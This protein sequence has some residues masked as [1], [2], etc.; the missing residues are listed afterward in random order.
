MFI[1]FLNLIL[2]NPMKKETIKE[3]V[4]KINKDGVIEEVK[5]AIDLVSLKEKVIQSV[6]VNQKSEIYG[7]LIF[8]L[9]VVLA[10]I[11][12]TISTPVFIAQYSFG[13]IILSV[14]SFLA[15]VYS[16]ILIADKGFKMK[17]DLRSVFRVMSYASIVLWPLVLQ[18][19]FSMINAYGIAR[20]FSVAN[21]FV[22]WIFVVLYF[23]LEKVIKMKHNDAI[24]VSVLSG[25]TYFL[26]STILGSAL[27]GGFY[28]G[29]GFYF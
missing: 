9:P 8:A 1:L 23:Y 6:S 26:V 20:I 7:A 12:S 5:K 4:S 13:L 14:V 22:L 15:S 27:F 24:I 18:S 10:F 11:F 28:S 17:L 19:F 3:E 25:V 16:V 21:Y 2:K 29:M